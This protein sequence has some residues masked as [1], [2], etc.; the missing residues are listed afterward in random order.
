M[1]IKIDKLEEYQIMP[2]EFLKD[3]NLSLKARGL[4]A[5]FYSLPNNWDYSVEGTKKIL[6]EGIACIR[7]TLAELELQG[8]LK[9]EQTKNEKG[10]FEY[11]YHIYLHKQKANIKDCLALKRFAKSKDIRI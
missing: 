9:R 1:R 2:T 6:K 7:S 3:K 11:I 10:Q 4:L 8:Y 5:T